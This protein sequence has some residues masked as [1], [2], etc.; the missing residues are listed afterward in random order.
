MVVMVVVNVEV[1]VSVVLPLMSLN[2]QVGEGEV[3][4]WQPWEVRGRG[5]SRAG[6][7][8][9]TPAVDLLSLLL[10]TH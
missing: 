10:L 2:N 1:V 3:T 9:V 6:V 5:L 4:L 7:V 8:W